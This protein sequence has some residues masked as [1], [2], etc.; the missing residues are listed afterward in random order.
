MK[1]MEL[2]RPPKQKPKSAKVS[3]YRTSDGNYISKA[4][5]DYRVK[6]AK[7]S[8]TQ[9]V[10]ESLGIEVHQVRCERCRLPNNKAP[11]VSRSHIISVDQCQKNGESELAYDLFNFEHLCMGCHTLWE[12]TSNRI[13]KAWFIYRKSEMENSRFAEFKYFFENIFSE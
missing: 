3:S 8:Y 9:T 2:Y 7:D 5:I 6:K 4:T 11:G 1:M 13:R 12:S 10:V